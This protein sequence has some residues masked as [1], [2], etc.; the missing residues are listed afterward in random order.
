MGFD[1]DRFET[2]VDDELLCAICKGVF[3][4][5][6][7]TPCEHVFCSSCINEWFE[8]HECTCPIDRKAIGATTNNVR[9]PAR[10]QNMSN[11]QVLN[12]IFEA[13]ARQNADCRALTG[14]IQVNQ[15]SGGPR[16]VEIFFKNF[17][18]TPQLTLTMMI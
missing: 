5:P 13:T 8:S 4:D 14:H 16:L 10:V 18:K 15:G 3:E 7:M 1:V 17:H 2:P 6:V 12:M 9:A 11:D